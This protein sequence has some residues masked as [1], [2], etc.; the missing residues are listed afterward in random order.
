MA[1]DDI[2]FAIAARDSGCAP[3]DVAALLADVTS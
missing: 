2:N 3:E 1:Y